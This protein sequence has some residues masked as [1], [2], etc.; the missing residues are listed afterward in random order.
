MNDAARRVSVVVP[1]HNRPAFLREALASIRAIEGPDLTFEILVCDNGT[2]PETRHAADEFGAVYLKAVRPGAAAARNVGLRAATSDYIAF[3]DDDDLWLSENVRPH[4]KLLDDRPELDVVLGQI[5]STDEAL[6]PISAPWPENGNLEG[7]ALLKRML[8]GYFPQLGGVVVR[9]VVRD[10]FGEFD[11]TLIGGEDLDWLLRPARKHRVAIVA[12]PCILFRG[13]PDGSYDTLQR[14][15]IGFD[16]RVFLRHAIPEWRIWSS[17][18]EFSRAHS[19]TMMHFYLYF[20]Q[21]ALDRARR[22]ER[23]AALRA[24][25]T[26]IRIFPLR[27]TYHLLKPRNLQLALRTALSR[28]TLQSHASN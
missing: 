26:A 2:A 7:S 9:S 11:E 23:R 20:V 16:R 25:M 22:G 18:L 6:K 19:D 12:V 21:A 14:L 5:I 1:T 27:G 17:P 8:S 24:I 13:R 28:K 3:L 10:R 15:R 4:L